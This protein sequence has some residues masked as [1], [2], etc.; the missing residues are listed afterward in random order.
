LVG[1]ALSHLINARALLD[2]ALPLMRAVA[3][4]G[5]RVERAPAAHRR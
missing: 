2:Y 4:D 3:A 5:D 1:D